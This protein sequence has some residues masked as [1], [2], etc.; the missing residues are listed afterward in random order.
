[1]ENNERKPFAMDSSLLLAKR[2]L[3]GDML[4]ASAR[5]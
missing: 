3:S 4:R 2:L 1:M 5:W